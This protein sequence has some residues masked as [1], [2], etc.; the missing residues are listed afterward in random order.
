MEIRKELINMDNDIKKNFIIFNAIMIERKFK[1]PIA[2]S[3]T[4]PVL[5]VLKNFKENN[6]KIIEYEYKLETSI[7]AI[8][9]YCEI[10][11]REITKS[12][13]IDISNLSSLDFIYLLNII[14]WLGDTQ[15]FEKEEFLNQFFSIYD[16]I[17]YISLLEPEAF[18][19]YVEFY[20]YDIFFLNK[21]KEIEKSFENESDELKNFIEKIIIK[22]YGSHYRIYSDENNNHFNKVI[23]NV[24]KIRIL[25][26]DGLNGKENDLLQIEKYNLHHLEWCSL[27]YEKK[28]NYAILQYDK[29]QKKM[30]HYDHHHLPRY[31]FYKDFYNFFTFLPEFSKLL[32]NSPFYRDQILLI[33]NIPNKKQS[34]KSK[35]YEEALDYINRTKPKKIII[36]KKEEE[37][38]LR[39]R[40][41]IKSQNQ[42][43]YI[44]NESESVVYARS[45]LNSYL[46][47]KELNQ[48]SKL[49]KEIKYD[50]KNC[51]IRDYYYTIKVLKS[52][53]K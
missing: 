25:T 38:R 33:L 32:W 2:I 27:T 9:Y 47:E 4:I 17:E 51:I 34:I 39:L 53:K 40:E 8:K 36:D 43:L 26:N 22:S 5:N 6:G 28:K 11:S 45:R 44:G 41:E 10:K 16:I 46:K 3:K 21:E 14:C 52:S 23:K 31:D 20:I 29:Y 18:A 7:E 49:S 24:M 13:I 48:S 37:L 1:I 15:L 35:N 19:K 30:G 42:S 12:T 50:R